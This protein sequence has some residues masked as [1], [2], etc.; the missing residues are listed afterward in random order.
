VGGDKTGVVY[1]SASV[2][3][4]DFADLTGIGTHPILRAHFRPADSSAANT[5]FYLYA[6]PEP[7]I[8]A[9]LVTGLLM[10]WCYRLSRQSYRIKQ[11]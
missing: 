9:L 8:L 3:L 11:G 4:L 2:T 1:N 6:V 5:E 7:S 10:A